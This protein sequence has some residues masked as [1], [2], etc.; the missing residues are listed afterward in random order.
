MYGRKEKITLYWMQ[1]IRIDAYRAEDVT[2]S[3]RKENSSD[4]SISCF[5]RCSGAETGN[6]SDSGG[7]DAMA[8]RG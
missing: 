6:A 8:E 7:N 1:E 3:K 2:A 4:G 5:M